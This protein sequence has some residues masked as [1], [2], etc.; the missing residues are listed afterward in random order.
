M[1]RTKLSP[2][3]HLDFSN[4]PLPED[5]NGP[6]QTAVTNLPR[7]EPPNQAGEEASERAFLRTEDVCL[8]LAGRPQPR[9][10]LTASPGLCV[11]D[12]VRLPP[13]SEIQ[14][15]TLHIQLAQHLQL[16][17]CAAEANLHPLTRKP[18]TGTQPDFHSTLTD[19]TSLIKDNKDELQ[20]KL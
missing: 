19:N 6:N 8:S 18:N 14:P 10:H 3:T 15:M 1:E 7:H 13:L 17:F 12:K 9:P 2:H 11:D 5:A 20:G 16:S 4:V